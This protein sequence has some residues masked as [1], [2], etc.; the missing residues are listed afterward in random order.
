MT[1]KIRD[2]ATDYGSDV[3][4]DGVIAIGQVVHD[5]GSVCQSVTD[6]A[7]ESGEAIAVEEFRTLNRCLDDAIA[8]AVSGYSA[9]QELD[10]CAETFEESLTV[11]NLVSTALHGFE[12][13]RSGRVAVGGAT[14]ILVHR[15][16]LALR[17][18]TEKR[19]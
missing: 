7:M 12:A 10:R 1:S 9:R 17:A 8:A 15:A 11:T 14:G 18:H 6:M 5:Y 19:P 3:A 2:H 13:L 16:L 4:A